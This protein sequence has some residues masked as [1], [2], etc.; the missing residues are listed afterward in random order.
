MKIV[1]FVM[2]KTYSVM[3][4]CIQLISNPYSIVLWNWIFFFFFFFFS[5]EG[6]YRLKLVQLEV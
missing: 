4:I 5:Q 3:Q 2:F 6:K 1:V